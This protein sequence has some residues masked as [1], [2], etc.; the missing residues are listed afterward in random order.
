MSQ[1]VIFDPLL[2]AV[3]LWILAAVAVALLVL[4]LWR[5]LA[6]WALR[7]LAAGFLLAALANPS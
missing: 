5:G 7:A 3:F 2:P 4:A 6:G 1:T